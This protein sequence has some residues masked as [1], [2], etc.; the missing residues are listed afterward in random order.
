MP[1]RD[2]SY[3]NGIV[4][5]KQLQEMPDYSNEATNATETMLGPFEY[6]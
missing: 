4:Y 5:A 3:S 6:D 1:S 2:E